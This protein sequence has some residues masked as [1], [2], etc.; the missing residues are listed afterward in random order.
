MKH[1]KRWRAVATG[2]T[3]A[4]AAGFAVTAQ[5]PEPPPIDLTA[6]TELAAASSDS[7]VV[8]ADDSPESPDSVDSADSVDAP[9]SPDSVDSP[10]SAD[11]DDGFSDVGRSNVHARNIDELARR[12]ITV[13][14]QDGTFRPSGSVTRAQL[15]TFLTRSLGLDPVPGQRFPD[16]DPGNV[17]APAINAVADAGIARG[18]A[19]GTFAPNQSIDRAQIASMLARAFELEATQRGRFRDVDPANVH[20]PAIDAIAE[21]GVSAG[22]TETTFRPGDTL[23][24]DQ[25]ASL[26]IRALEL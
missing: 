16:V 21:A 24:R 5:S 20:A 23:R 26:L 7:P 25:M 4:L 14:Y 12:G 3:V 6:E 9:D 15:A 13:G 18:L 11:S 2:A 19:D 8:A 1:L 17:H 10:S 22:A